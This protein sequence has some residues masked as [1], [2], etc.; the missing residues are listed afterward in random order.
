MIDLNFLMFITYSS[1]SSKFA[2]SFQ[3]SIFHG[4]RINYCDNHVNFQD[5]ELQFQEN[6]VHQFNHYRFL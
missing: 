2:I 5:T 6:I 3:F 1:L 4:K